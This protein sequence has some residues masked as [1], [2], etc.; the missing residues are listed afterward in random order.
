MKPQKETLTREMLVI[1]KKKDNQDTSGGMF[2]HFMPLC[3][4]YGASGVLEVLTYSTFDIQ[5]FKEW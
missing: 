2:P 5:L 3:N 1:I 4:I